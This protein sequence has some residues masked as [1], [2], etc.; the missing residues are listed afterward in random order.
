MVSDIYSFLWRRESSANQM[1]NRLGLTE[2]S[3]VVALSSPHE[4]VPGAAG[5]LLPQYQARLLRE[6]G[7]EI[8][9]FDQPGELVLSSPSIV[10]GYVGDDQ[11]NATTFKDGWLHTGDVAL[12]HRSPAGDAYLCIVDR[13]RDMIKVKVRLHIRS[14]SLPSYPPRS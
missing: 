13:L 12:F 14:Q 4:H 2:S 7:G 5:T 3:A 8:D 1:C 11:S 10:L 6:D 9:D